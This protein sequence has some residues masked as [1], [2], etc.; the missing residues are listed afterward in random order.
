MK[1]FFFPDKAHSRWLILLIDQMIV[2][3]TLFI[4]ILLTHTLSYQD[5]FNASNAMYVG[6]YCAIAAGVFITL[7]IHTGI[8]RY[9]NTEDILRVFLAVFVTSLLFIGVNKILSQRFQL[10]WSEMDKALI[11]NFFISSSLLIL[12]RTL[13]KGVFYFFKELK[14]E[15]KENIL[16]YGSEKKAI[17]IKN[18]IEQ[19]EDSNLNIIGFV[20]DNRDR[21]DK[22]LEQKKVYHSCSVEFLKE[23][24]GIKKILFA[25]D[26]LNTLNKKKIIDTCVNQGIK[27][28]MVPPS[29]KW[30][31]GKLDSH[32]LRDLKI[33]DLLEREPIK[34]NKK[35]ILK[36][37]SGKCILVTGAAGSIGSE[38]V[39]QALHYN[40]KM[41]ILCDQAETP[42]H[43]LKLELEDNF[44]AA[45]VKIFMAN[46]QNIN[47]IRTLF[48][49]YKPE[50]VFHAAAYKHVP[51]MEDNPAEAVLTNVLGTKN[52][53][54][55]SMEFGVEK[56]VMIS[57][58]KAVK[59]TN[60]MGA[61]K[62]LAEIYIQSLNSPE[63]LPN[64]EITTHA[65]RT[66]FVTTR[67]GNVLGSNGSVIPRFKSQIERRGPITVTDPE[68]TRYFMTI[69]E[70]VQLVME[71]G[72]MGKGG[73]IFLFD[74]G[75]PIKI[76]DLA[77]NM[78]KLAGLTPYNDIDIV[79]TG[80]RPGEKLYEELLLMEEEIMATHHP[81]IKISQKVA[82]NYLYVNQII[83]DL[84]VLNND[85]NDL[86]MV[87]K[88]K[89]IIPDY[90]SNNSRYE[91]L[92][93]LVAN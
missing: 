32:Q 79:F 86:N 87:K 10:L 39:R 54:D 23:K 14:S 85:G 84:I 74:M 52:M 70:A 6:L 57:T 16:I 49:L 43:D 93:L 67:F 44:Q 50:I 66:R 3:W 56:F 60:V 78:I 45:N 9:S 64:G 88:M 28:I 58:D 83:K 33:E 89:E 29:D 5:I 7:R 24:H 75:K 13:V 69:P 91:E 30:L 55:V 76:V 12:M 17:L 35:N 15:T 34:L 11:L 42:L 4:A 62:R 71:A 81:K 92:D 46:V 61:S 20:D 53:A 73:E 80:L 72:A 41:V 8:I 36:D 37:L 47:R 31:Y 82:Y 18:A 65:S 26:A 51:M 59:P 21:V 68:I 1:N 27:V 77:I 90:I 48:E 2:V 40:P 63:T 19:N 38:I 22:Y 25:E